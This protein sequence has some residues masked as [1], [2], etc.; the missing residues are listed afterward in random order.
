MSSDHLSGDVREDAALVVDLPGRRQPRR[1]L[2]RRH[3]QD[4][5]ELV[6]N[7]KFQIIQLLILIFSVCLRSDFEECQGDQIVDILQIKLN[8]S[9]VSKFEG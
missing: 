5:V 2:R 9:K 3:H 4:T 8:F 7:F 6:K 1:R